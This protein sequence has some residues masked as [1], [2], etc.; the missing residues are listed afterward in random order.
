MS[1]LAEKVHL[2]TDERRAALGLLPLRGYAPI[3]DGTSERGLTVEDVE[4]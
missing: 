2:P 3:W 1:R 4:A